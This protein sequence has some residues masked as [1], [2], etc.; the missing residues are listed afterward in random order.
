MPFR[1]NHIETS[2]VDFMPVW[3]WYNIEGFLPHNGTQFQYPRE[4]RPKP[5][6]LQ[7]QCLLEPENHTASTSVNHSH[8]IYRIYILL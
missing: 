7:E 5:V 2:K 1:F 8:V 4:C 6:A 3:I